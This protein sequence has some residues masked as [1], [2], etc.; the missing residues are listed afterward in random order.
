MGGGLVSVYGRLFCFGVENMCI[1]LFVGVVV[2]FGLVFGMLLM[3]VIFV[4]E[5]LFIG[6]M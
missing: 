2:G 4:M 3:G 5:V 1:L 6:C